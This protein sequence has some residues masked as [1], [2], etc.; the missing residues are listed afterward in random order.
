MDIKE[1][2]RAKLGYLVY[3]SMA[4]EPSVASMYHTGNH[5]FALYSFVISVYLTELPS[6][7]LEPS[8][9]S[10]YPT[11]HPNLAKDHSVKSHYMSVLLI[12]RPNNHVMAQSLSLFPMM[13]LTT[14]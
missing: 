1:G 14:Y 11:E 12:I 2:S 6:M 3:P 7:A 5:S 4:L 13:S 9:M 10:M 8:V